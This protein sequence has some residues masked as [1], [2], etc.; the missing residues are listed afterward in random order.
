MT[1]QVHLPSR[2][3][4]IDTAPFCEIILSSLSIHRQFLFSRTKTQEMTGINVSSHDFLEEIV[5][6]S[7]GMGDQEDT[8]TGEGMI[9]I[10][11]DLS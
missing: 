1:R 8:L 9:K 11:D 3:G 7:V 6:G 5:Q 4:I 2:Q 10:G